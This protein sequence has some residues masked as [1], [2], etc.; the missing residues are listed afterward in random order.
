MTKYIVEHH[1]NDAKPVFCQSAEEAIATAESID[2]V[3][4]MKYTKYLKNG[5]P[6]VFW[7]R[8]N[9]GRWESR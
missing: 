6:S 7:K 3:A 1:P 2:G 4:W 9:N 5:C 8:Y